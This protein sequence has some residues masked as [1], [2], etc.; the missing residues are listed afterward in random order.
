MYRGEEGSEVWAANEVG[1]LNGW[2]DRGSQCAPELVTVISGGKWLLVYRLF[3]C[4]YTY[5]MSESTTPSA[6]GEGLQQS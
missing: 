4:E 5:Y 1:G 6:S 2:V 3:I